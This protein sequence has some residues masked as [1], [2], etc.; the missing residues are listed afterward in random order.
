M[1]I[2][3]VEDD[4]DVREYLQFVLE[5]A[6]HL[7]VAATTGR[8]AVRWLQE[9][10][11]P[12]LILLDVR[13]PDRG[14]DGLDICRALKKDLGS[15]KIPVIILT[16]QRSNEARIEAG[17]AQADL[18]LTKP[19]KAPELLK[20]IDLLLSAR[21][22]DRRGLLQKGG[23]EIDPEQRTVFYNGKIVRDLSERLFDLLYLLGAQAPNTLSRKYILS[24]LHLQDRDREV[25][26]LISRLRKK[27]HREFGLNLVATIS[28]EGYRLDLNVPRASLPV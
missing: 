2:L 19:I 4:P 17:Q 5:R 22:G 18:F 23:M 13:L 27:L 3:V 14:M 1:K 25:D 7:V 16:G 28:H 6:G 26:V 10:G 11:K 8:I 15:R 21:A 9:P 20:A 12:D 24:E